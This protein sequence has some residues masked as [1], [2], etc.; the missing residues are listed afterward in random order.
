MT[1]MKIF[2]LAQKNTLIFVSHNSTMLLK[3]IDNILSNLLYIVPISRL[4]NSLIFNV[5]A[6]GASSDPCSNTYAGPVPSSELE[7]QSISNYVLNL[8]QSGNVIYYFAFH[9]YSQMVLIPYSH[10]SGMDVLQ[11]SN[12]ADMVGKTLYKYN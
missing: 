2:T 12:Y 10:V 9:S 6:T 8:K 11:A 5:T 1:K 3:F 4:S 7:A